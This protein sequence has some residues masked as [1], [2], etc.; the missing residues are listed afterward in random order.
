MRAVRRGFGRLLPLARLLERFR[1]YAE[2]GYFVLD[3]AFGGAEHF[4]GLGLV[5]ALIVFNYHE[6]LGLAPKRIKPS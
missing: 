5:A 1:V 2:F 4:G 6:L 3:D